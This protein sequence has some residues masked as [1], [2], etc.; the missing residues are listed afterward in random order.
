WADTADKNLLRIRPSDDKAADA[1][2]ISGSSV[3]NSSASIL[4][5]N[6][7]MMVESLSPVDR[8]LDQPAYTECMLDATPFSH[9]VELRKEVAG[10][11]CLHKPDRAAPRQFAHAQARCETHD[12]VLLA[13]SDSGE[14]LALG[15]STQAT[16]MAGRL[17]EFAVET[18]TFVR[19][20]SFNSYQVARSFLR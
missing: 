9:V 7:S 2:L 11:H 16:R 1:D 20:S 5:R 19:W 8:K 18:S 6:A 15:L 17:E 4:F 10:K 12:L 14:M 3:T 13:Q